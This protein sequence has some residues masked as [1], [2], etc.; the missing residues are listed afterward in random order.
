[1]TAAKRRFHERRLASVQTLEVG[2]ERDRFVAETATKIEQLQATIRVLTRD[3]EELVGN[4]AEVREI[5]GQDHRLYAFQQNEK[6]AKDSKI[7]E[8]VRSFRG[9]KARLDKIEARTD[10]DYHAY[11][12][13]EAVSRK[14]HQLEHSR[15]RAG[16]RGD[17]FRAWL[18]CCTLIAATAMIGLSILPY[19]LLLKS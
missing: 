10:G 9:L 14:L 13:F 11:G 2:P 4:V 17:T 15:G 1:M 19:Q 8:M 12:S 3:V 7:D 6:H 5:A 16:N 18:L